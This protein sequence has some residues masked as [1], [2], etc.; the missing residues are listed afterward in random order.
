AVQR[1]K[2]IGVRKVLG[3]SVLNLWKILSKDFVVHVL[4]SLCIAV[5][6][7]YYFMYQWLLQFQYRSPLSWWIFV[8]AGLGAIVI[9]LLTISYQSIKAALANPVN[10]LR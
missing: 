7:A 10:S 4:I 9:T 3:A 5:P 8:S 6:T 1:T 2:E